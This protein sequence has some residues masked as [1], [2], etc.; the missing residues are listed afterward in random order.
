MNREGR[1]KRIDHIGNTEEIPTTRTVADFKSQRWIADR[2]YRLMGRS[3][4]FWD[5][6][7]EGLVSASCAG[8][9]FRPQGGQR[10]DQMR[11]RGPQGKHSDGQT[12]GKAC[13]ERGKPGAHGDGDG[14]LLSSR[15]LLYECRLGDFRLRRPGAD[16]ADGQ[17]SQQFRQSNPV[18]LVPMERVEIPFEGKS[19]QESSL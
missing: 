7:E 17:D 12:L 11:R 3:A 6:P 10:E 4:F 15:S 16:L 9:L 8:Q 14:L 18:Q 2:F 13:Q 1:I 5:N 19:I